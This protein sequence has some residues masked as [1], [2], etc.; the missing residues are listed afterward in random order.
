MSATIITPAENSGQEDSNGQSQEDEKEIDAMSLEEVDTD[1]SDTGVHTIVFQN[2][3][4]REE[5]GPTAHRPS[6]IYDRPGM[7]AE[8]DAEEES[9]DESVS[10]GFDGPQY[11]SY[12]DESYSFEEEVVPI[13]RAKKQRESRR[14]RRPHVS[15]NDY[16][17]DEVEYSTLRKGTMEF[18]TVEEPEHVDHVLGNLRPGGAAGPRDAEKRSL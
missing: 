3:S 6:F 9:S 17:S 1:I 8:N 5:S 4:P 15:V 10:T 11:Q 13:R 16:I 14:R 18:V 7:H 12:S 2:P